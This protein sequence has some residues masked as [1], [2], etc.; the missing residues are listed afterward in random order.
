MCN[1]RN[2]E[3]CP[4]L[5]KRG[6]FDDPL[7]TGSSPRV[8]KTIESAL[9]YC[10][11]LL[12]PGG[13]CE[14]SLPSAYSVWRK[15]SEKQCLGQEYHKFIYKHPKTGNGK[16][17]LKVNYV[18]V[19]L[20]EKGRS[21]YL[22]IIF[23]SI[24]IMMFGLC[25]IVELQDI[26]VVFTWVLT[27][28]AERDVDEAVV[29]TARDSEINTAR[30]R[31]SVA[32]TARVSSE[33]A[34]DLSARSEG[35]AQKHTIHGITFKHRM[36][37][38]CLSV[39]RFI[40]AILLLWVGTVFLIQDTDYLNLL[41]NGVAL[42]FVIEI[43]NCLYGQLISEELR[44]KFEET[45]PFSVSMAS[46]WK[47]VWFRNPAMRDFFRLALILAVLFT[48]MYM[49]YVHI[50]KPLS[51]ALECACLS[52]GKQCFEADQY[53]TNFW[54]TYWG[55]DVPEIFAS[56][57]KMKKE[58]G[59]ADA[60]ADYIADADDQ[61]VEALDEPTPPAGHAAANN[62]I[63]KGLNGKTQ[64]FTTLKVH[65]QDVETSSVQRRQSRHTI[66]DVPRFLNGQHRSAIPRRIE[67]NF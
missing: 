16:S 32:G 20:Y 7:M 64:Q 50:A 31:E 27:F 15:A 40:L 45:E 22:F 33:S 10:Y 47:W 65:P 4:N 42:V 60:D 35:G 54:K 38:C 56:V 51:R 57:K 8:G 36:L 5:L 6:F 23:K 46:T 11:E 37:V 14:R 53:D 48:G 24:I 18:A 19:S 49:H 28:P 29:V 26:L 41:L 63:A 66:R 25:M 61:G 1:Y 67:V 2:V 44:E 62:F 12:K 9:N 3:M 58:H 13:V 21:S 30:S 52:Q 59:I 34:G 43:A 55:H 39:V 17:L